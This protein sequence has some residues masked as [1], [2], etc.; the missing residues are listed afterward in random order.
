[1]LLHFVVYIDDAQRITTSQKIPY[2]PLCANFELSM[3]SFGEDAFQNGNIS[4]EYRRA[5]EMW[6]PCAIKL[7]KNCKGKNVKREEY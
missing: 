4:P 6:E 1:M 3:V 5:I 7:D 2:F